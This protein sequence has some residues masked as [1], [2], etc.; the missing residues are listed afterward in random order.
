MGMIEIAGAAM[1]I[2]AAAPPLPPPPPPPPILDTKTT[3]AGQ[4]LEVPAGPIELVVRR[5][6]LPA[7]HPIAVH[8]HFWSRYVYVEQGEVTLTLIKTGRSFTFS[9]GHVIPEPIR[10]W[11]KAVVSSSGPATL[12]VFDQVP[13]GAENEIEPPL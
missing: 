9:A 6:T 7:G 13:P 4:P 1:L 12:V 8:L 5:V 11:H 2:A 10:L 3:V